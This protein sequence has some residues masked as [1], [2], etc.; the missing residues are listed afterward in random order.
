MLSNT[1]QIHG[2]KTLRNLVLVCH[3]L[4]AIYTPLLFSSMT[5]Q[6]NKIDVETEQCFQLPVGGSCVRE[7]RVFMGNV[8]KGREVQEDI[9]YDPYS[10]YLTHLVEAL[11]N[12]ISFW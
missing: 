3:E 12:L 2:R 5:C 11:P 10:Q 1:K 6:T 9:M 7:L 8:Y 4:R